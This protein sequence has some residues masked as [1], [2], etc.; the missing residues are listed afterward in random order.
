MERRPRKRRSRLALETLVECALNHHASSSDEHTLRSADALL[1]DTVVP[2]LS[3]RANSPS[4]GDELA[5]TSGHR[6]S[7]DGTDERLVHE[8]FAVR[9]G[10]NPRALAVCAPDATLSYG[11][12]ERRANQLAHHLRAL[13]VDRDI[14][15]GLCLDRSAAMVV[16]ALGILKAGG[17]YVALD[18]RDPTDRLRF[19]VRDCGTEVLVTSATMA[20]QL[21]GLRANVV[22]LDHP[23]VAQG[24]EPTA[25]P[26]ATNRVDDLAYVIYTSGSTGFPKGVLVQHDGLGNLNSWHQRTFGISRTDRATQIASPAFDAA[27]WELWPYLTAGASV[28]IPA[29]E[30]RVDPVAIRD[31]LIAE[32]ITVCFLPTML[33]ELVMTLYWPSKPA[34]RYLLTGGDTLHG[35]PRSDL[36]FAVINNYGPTE[37]TVVATSGLVAPGPD[38]ARTPSIGRP[39]SNVRTYIVDESLNQVPSGSIG[40]LLIGGPGVARGYLG[41]PELTIEKFI[42]DRFDSTPDARLYRTGDN[43]R[44]HP[45]GE[46]EFHGRRDQQVQIR[47]NRVELGEISAILHRHAAVRL[48]AV[49]LEDRPTEPRL[50]AYVV[51]GEPRPSPVELRDLLARQ[52]PNYMVP[53][54]FVYLDAMPLTA[55]GKIDRAR[56]PSP[57]PARSAS[58]SPSTRAHTDLEQVLGTLLAE[59]LELEH[60]EIDEN[61]FML[62]GHS[63]LG[64]QL[65][66]RIARRFGV[67]ISLRSLFDTPTVAGM[68]VE[69]ERLLVADL[70]AMTDADA[71]RLLAAGA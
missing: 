45:D 23:G 14:P 4:E 52:L 8:L 6:T 61:F 47:G 13:G 9:A 1:K 35:R 66:A 34:L 2:Q 71:A 69:V 39:I 42:P 64:A 41:R 27:V 24:Y 49:V 15:V 3:N 65:A 62:G 21:P 68:A 58:P 31:W 29:E 11:E 46:L 43:V 40:E 51:C 55:S 70:A 37:A 19:K 60:V 32:R 10:Q 48:S 5:L 12:L 63:L 56:L 36:P 26:S 7:S 50:I 38:I 25:P 30:V 59:L 18:P 44:R 17:A 33:A 20:S 67:E 53:A 54:T 22:S 28:H 57:V 16:G